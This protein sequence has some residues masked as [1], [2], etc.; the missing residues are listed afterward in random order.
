MTKKKCCGCISDFDE[1]PEDY[2]GDFE[3]EFDEE[4][5]EAA[6]SDWYREKT[7]HEKVADILDECKNLLLLKG[8]DYNSG[9]VKM[10]DYYPRGL[11]S[12]IDL[13]HAKLLRMYSLLESNEEANFESIEDSAKDLI[14]YA[15]IFVGVSRGLIETP[16]N[17][18]WPK[19]YH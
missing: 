10:G 7:D 18:K 17:E 15:A 13:M 9:R 11:H 1:L 8:R 5:L 2:E 19:G 6:Q 12:V 4:E 14:N 3:I 16:F